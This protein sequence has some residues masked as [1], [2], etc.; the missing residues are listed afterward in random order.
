MGGRITWSG[1]RRSWKMSSKVGM[2]SSDDLRK[3]VPL[4]HLPHHLLHATSLVLPL[5]ESGPELGGLAVPVPNG[6][7]SPSH[8]H[9]K[10]VIVYRIFLVRMTFVSDVIIVDGFNQG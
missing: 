5:R 2:I 9:G 6:R 3:P 1:G 4:F 8:Q 7:P 10:S